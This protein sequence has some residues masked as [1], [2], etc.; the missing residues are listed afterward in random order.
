VIEFFPGTSENHLFV[1]DF[2]YLFAYLIILKCVC[3]VRMDTVAEINF[4]T[5][6][7]WV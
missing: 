2:G 4:L 6:E 5:V 7:M 3:K 1:I